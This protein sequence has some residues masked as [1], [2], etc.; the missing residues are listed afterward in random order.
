MSHLR[1][2]S[3]AVVALLGVSMSVVARAETSQQSLMKQC[4]IEANA[5]HMMGRD[6]QTFMKSCLSGPA[7]G[8][9]ELNS[10]QRRMKDCNAQA[11]AKGLM[12]ADRK[13]YMSSCLKGR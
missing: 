8:H 6:R 2:A 4:N 5:K 9:Q 7:R 3:L 1:I 12:G 13:H 11:K 10:Q